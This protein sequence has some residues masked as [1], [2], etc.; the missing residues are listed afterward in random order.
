M[1]YEVAKRAADFLFENAKLDSTIPSITFFGGEPML[2]W[3]RV[4]K[5]LCEYIRKTYHADYLLSITTNGTLFT[6][7]RLQFL[8]QVDCSILLSI[9]G[10]QKTQDL[11]RPCKAN[12]ISSYDCIRENIPEL[13]R[14]FPSTTFRSTVTPETSAY[15]FDN[16]LES[17][18]LGFRHYFVMP[19]CFEPWDNESKHNLQLAIK[20][21]ADYYISFF[22]NNDKPLYFRSF[23]DNFK[24]II[25]LNDSIKNDL[26]REA[27]VCKTCNKCGL[28]QS[29]YGAI[30]WNGDI[31]TCQEYFTYDYEQFLIGNIFDGVDSK[32]R[33]ELKEL[34]QAKNIHSMGDECRECPLFRICD[35]GCIANN[36]L[37]YGDLH[38]VSDIYCYWSKILFEEAKRV[39]VYLGSINNQLFIERWRR[40]IYGT[41]Y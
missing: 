20:S 11:I 21:Y 39:A 4:V 18:S 3:D 41:D 13:L 30:N 33:A 36:Y 24:R 35:G 19:N 8:K 23:E 5:P 2:E 10:A 40:V 15:L 29:K 16:M 1:S 27:G 14:L 12:G 31:L 28:G 25:L 9:D 22:E 38:A 26:V 34:F 37:R 6:P 17:V 7:D 32:K